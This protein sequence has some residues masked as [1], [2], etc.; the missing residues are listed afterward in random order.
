MKANKE[1]EKR[2]KQLSDILD[3]FNKSQAASASS[4]LP[5]ISKFVPEFTH[6]IVSKIRMKIVNYISMGNAPAEVTEGIFTLLLSMFRGVDNSRPE[7]DPYELLNCDNEFL[8]GIFMHTGL[9]EEGRFNPKVIEIIYKHLLVKQ[10]ERMIQFLLESKESVFSLMNSLADPNG[11]R[12]YDAACLFNQLFVCNPT[13]S[14]SLVYDVIPLLKKFRPNLVIDLMISNQSIKKAMSQAEFEEWL[15]E[16]ESF[17]LSDVQEVFKLYKS[18]WQS[19]LPIEM[20]L[21][22]SPPQ[23][24]HEIKWIHD[25]PVQNI[26]VPPELAQRTIEQI[27][28]P[29]YDFFLLD[30]EAPPL[31]SANASLVSSYSQFTMNNS[32]NSQLNTPINTPLK[33]PIKSPNNMNSILNSPIGNTAANTSIFGVSP[34]STLI[35]SRGA[36]ST[37]DLYLFPRLY[38]LSLCNPADIDEQYIPMI[39]DLMY[40]QNEYVSAGAIQV[41]VLWVAKYGLEIEYSLIYRIAEEIDSMRKEAIKGLYRILLQLMAVKHKVAEMMLRTEPNLRY[42]Q[43]NR[44]LIMRS[45][46]EFKNF[47]EILQNVP[48]FDK[49]DQKT[50]LL[51]LNEISE[52]LGFEYDEVEE[53]A[54]E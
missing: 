15:L 7:T 21:R 1:R 54:N 43:R 40:E 23:K 32:M 41:I 2:K 13:V 46:W 51:V 52:Y 28:N 38:I 53:D 34:T 14:E 33:T 22:S 37:R 12:D 20:I 19:L 31:S 3:R 4:F 9:G 29:Q 25:M 45:A 5:E 44:A 30:E 35:G 24:E 18:I 17:T 6:F 42:T 27:I 49:Y 26:D 11:S 50:M 39:I 47:G 48:M 8:T 10:S 36:C 16:Q